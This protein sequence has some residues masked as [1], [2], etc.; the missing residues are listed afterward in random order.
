LAFAG[1]AI[2]LSLPARV[3]P[4]M[5]FLAPVILLA[6]LISAAAEPLLPTAEG[7]TWNYVLVQEKVSGNLD[8]TEPNELE[9]ISVTYRMGGNEKIDDKKL[10]RFEI[11]RDDSL[12]SVDLI[13]VEENGIIC[14]AR[15]YA[16]GRV[17]KL[18]PPQTM[19]ATPL[20]KGKRWT[21]EG[22]IGEIKVNQHYEIADQEEIE[23]PA[24]NFHAWR[25]HCDQ[26][27][28]A[29][30][31]IDRWFVPG[32]GF[33]KVATVVKGESGIA[34]QRSW[35]NLKELPK[36]AVQKNAS[37]ESNKLTGDISSEPQ[38]ELKTELKESAAT[39]YAR[40]HGRGLPDH[41]KIRAV[42]IAENVADISANSQIDEMETTAPTA[43]SGGT[44]ALSRPEGGWTT[45]DYR[46]EFYL[47][48]T[49]AD[50]A[51]FKIVK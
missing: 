26:D 38:G 8:L 30:A 32:I 23:V 39:V 46:V 15:I 10:Q 6:S 7:T 45:G 9:R 18:V 5:K 44:F 21:F 1:D 37:S 3:S 13:A 11:Y 16:G 27:S 14:P 36:I 48:D 20:A 40:W 50:T 34:A 12:D 17:V 51:K 33:V 2:E 28:P 19:L 24:G 22:T 31:T 41:A 4:K 47:D 42:F 49:L 29:P 25:I 43:N 35:L